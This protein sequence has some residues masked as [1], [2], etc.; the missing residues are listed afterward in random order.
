MIADRDM[1][2]TR[3]GVRV[4][5]YTSFI[6]RGFGHSHPAPPNEARQTLFEIE[7]RGGAKGFAFGVPADLV[8]RTLK[9]M[10]IGENALYRE[11]I[12][13]KLSEL[14]RGNGSTLSDAHMALV[15]VALW[16]LAGRAVGLPVQKLLGAFRDKIP[17]Y[18]STMCGDADLK[19]G[20]TSPEAYADFAEQCKEQ[21]YTAFKMHPW[22]PPVPGAPSVDRDI[23]MC[24]AVRKRVGDGMHLML[25]PYHQYSRQEAK[26]IGRAIEELG[27]LW[28][29]EPM[30][31]ASVSSYTWLCNELDLDVCGPETAPGQ[32]W[33]RAEWVKAGACDILRTGVL[34]VGGIT[35]MMKTI[36]LAEAHGMSIELHQ[37]GAATLQ[38]LGAM[39]IPGRFFERGLLH[40][41]IDYTKRT[42]WLATLE[43][44]MD[45][46]GFVHVPTGPGI[47]WDIDWDFIAA[48][49]VK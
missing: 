26:K 32:I 43:D 30:R 27:F 24:V 7:T 48:N 36:H 10:L 41:L 45:K 12:W 46:D 2:I 39:Q 42:P 47:G 31:E 33:T 4:F 1:E 35:P 44:P 49:E 25:D 20:L 21:G 37:N 23:E 17:A 40:P 28:M 5:T 15:D 14:Q 11:K 22:M 16:D 6:R 13:Q 19:G 3:L 8:E 18:A 29:E 34:D 38:A 9:P